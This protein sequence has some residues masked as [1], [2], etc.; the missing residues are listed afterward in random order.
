MVHKSTKRFVYS[1]TEFMNRENVPD[2][3]RKIWESYLRKLE[4]NAG[5]SIRAFARDLG[6]DMGHLTRVLT[7]KRRMRPSTAHRIKDRLGITGPAGLDFVRSA[8][9]VD[10][11]RGAK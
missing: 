11:G 3:V 5:Y 4:S 1:T 2:G 9:F 10:K 8:A 6:V 7:G